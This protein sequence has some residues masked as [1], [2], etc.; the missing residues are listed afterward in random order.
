MPIKKQWNTLYK[1]V[2][3]F[4]LKEIQKSKEALKRLP[5]LR[6]GEE[7][8]ALLETITHTRYREKPG[9]LANLFFSHKEFQNKIL[10]DDRETTESIQI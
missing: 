7:I 8:T 2:K 1:E 5:E 6:F 10:P 9:Y 3:I 4:E